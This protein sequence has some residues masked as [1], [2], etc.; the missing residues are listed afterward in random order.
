M[1]SQPLRVEE[2][3]RPVWFV[4]IRAL[5]FVLIPVLLLIIILRHVDLDELKARIGQTNLWL[6]GIGWAFQTTVTMVG[7]LR[8]RGVV[9]SYLR[10]PPPFWGMLRDYWIGLSLGLVA[11]G[12]LGSDIYRVTVVG[13]RFGGFLRGF[14]VI[15]T[16]K[17]SALV[18]AVAMIG[19]L[20]PAAVQLAVE[21]P[22]PAKTLFWSASLLL[23]LLGGA[24][25]GWALLKKRTSGRGLWAPVQQFIL[26]RIRRM[27]AVLKRPISFDPKALTFDVLIRPVLRLPRVG[28]VLFLSLGIFLFS[29][30]ANELYFQ[31]VGFEFPFLLN[32]FI[33]P[34]LFLTLTIPISFGNLGVREGAYVLLFGLFGVPAET[35]LLVSFFNFL[36]FLINCLIGAI[37]IWIGGGIGR[38]RGTVE[39]A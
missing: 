38:G 5:L 30:G 11:P 4:R 18:A 25:C 10:G 16:E 14:M 19:L 7:A 37:L 13:K 34:V 24:L 9:R 20:F 1:V 12:P 32:L 22:V 23:G 39:L 33:V 27:S 31:A 17:T 26:R 8:W 36:G 35:A 28:E 29:A 6:L 15:L 3:A 21:D 2:E